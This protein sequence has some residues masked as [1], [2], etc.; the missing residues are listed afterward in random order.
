MSLSGLGRASAKPAGGVTTVELVPAAGFT[1]VQY[2]RDGEYFSGVETSE[3]F[4]AYVFRE[5]RADY[6]EEASA[7]A[8]QLLVKHRLSMEFPAGPAARRAVDELSGRGA[9]GLVALIT[10]GSGERLIAGYSSRFGKLYPLRIA[11]VSSVSGSRPSDFPAVTV[12]LE[13]TD[14]EYSKPLKD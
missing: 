10:M 3:P 12:V 8:G 11:R 9:S 14:A 4:A 1:G 13:S 2:H 6:S 7:D 5:D